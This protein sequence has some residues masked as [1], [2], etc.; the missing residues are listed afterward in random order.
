MRRQGSLVVV[1][2]FSG[3]GKGTVIQSL[4]EKSDLYALSIS[5]TTREARPQET[6]GIEYFFVSEQRFNEMIR[7]NELI[8]F[9][10]YCENFYGTPRGFVEEQMMLGKDVILEIETQGAKKIREQYP[11]ALLVFIMPPSGEELRNR[12]AGRGSESERVIEQRLRRA[13]K[14]PESIKDYSYVFFNDDAQVCAQ[15][16]HHLIQAQR[17]RIERNDEKIR[18]V[19]DDLFGYLKGEE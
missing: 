10:S 12:L 14:E 6:H 9:A 16:L 17:N 4:M 19:C 2:G 11:D 18:E 7:N 13:G 5:A 8:E 1:S 15:E 3:V